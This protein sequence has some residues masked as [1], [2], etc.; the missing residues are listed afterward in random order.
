VGYTVLD[1]IRGRDGGGG[2]K[3]GGGIRRGMGWS[4]RVGFKANA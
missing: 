2:V 1:L 3:R 4:G